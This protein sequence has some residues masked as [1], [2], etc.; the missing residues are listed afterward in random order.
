MI[1]A[2]LFKSIFILFVTL[3]CVT[4]GVHAQLGDPV[5]QYPVSAS[6]FV[7]DTQRN[8]IIVSLTN[9]NAVAIIDNNSQTAMSVIPTG[10]LAPIGVA[11]SADNNELYV[12]SSITPMIEV[13]DINTMMPVRS[14]S[15]PY[16]VY[17][18]AV[19]KNNVLFATPNSV[20]N[21]GIM[22]IDTVNGFVFNQFDDNGN[23]LVYQG[24]LLAVSPDK[25]ILYFGNRGLSPA[26]LASFDISQPMSIPQLIFKNPHGSLG[27]NGQDIALTRDGQFISFAVGGGNNTIGYDIN[28]LTT[29][30]FNTVGMFT[31][32]A[33]PEEIV[34]NDDGSLAFTVHTSG[35]IDVFDANT[36][37]QVSTIVT[38]AK[39]AELFIDNSGLKLYAAFDGVLEVYSAVNFVMPISN[40]YFSDPA[41]KACFD[42]Q[43][44][45]HGWQFME[46]ITELACPG[47][48]IVDINGI[49]MLPRLKK[50]D[51]SDNAIGFIDSLRQISSLR[52]LRINKNVIMDVNPLQDLAG[53]E[54]LHIG[55]NPFDVYMLAPAINNMRGLK[56]LGLAGMAIQDINMLP[57]FDPDLGQP[58]DIQELDL[59]RTGYQFTTALTQFQ[60]LHILNLADN[61]QLDLQPLTMMTSLQQF[62]VANNVDIDMFMLQQVIANNH[63]LTHLNLNNIFIADVGN[64]PLFNP[65]LGQPYDIQ[66]LHLA[67]TGL[68][69]IQLYDFPNLHVL[70]VSKN[71][72]EMLWPPTTLTSLR[73][74]D[75]SGNAGLQLPQVRSV[76]E[77]NPQ[78]QELGL[79]DIRIEKI[80]NLPLFNPANGTPL[81]IRAL[82]LRN[83]GLRSLWGIEML[84]NL[85]ALDVSDNNVADILLLQML[86]QLRELDLSGNIAITEIDLF[87]VLGNKPKL[88]KLGLAGI[89]LPDLNSL[90]LFDNLSGRPY[91]LKSLNL[92]N[93]G[94]TDIYRLQEFATL[95]ELDL[96]Q[97]YIVDL[98]PLQILNKLRKLDLSGNL[99]LSV[100]SLY[101]ALDMKPRLT[102]LGLADI[103]IVDLYILPLFDYYQNRPYPLEEIN[104]RNTGIQS[105][106]RLVEFANLRKIDVSHNRIADIYPLGMMSRITDLDLGYNKLFDVWPLLSAGLFKLNALDLSGNTQLVMG[107]VMQ[108]IQ[109]NAHLTR[110][111]VAGFPLQ[112]LGYL[113]I[114]N[115]ASGGPY[116]LEYLNVEN[117]GLAEIY[118]LSQFKTLREVNISNNQLSDLAPLSAL[119]RL[120]AVT[121]RSVNAMNLNGME[122]YTGLRVLDVSGNN[123]LDP[124]Q[125]SFIVGNNRLLCELGVN[126]VQFADLGMLN[127]FDQEYQRPYALSRLDIK[128]TGLSQINI[129]EQFVT[130]QSLNIASNALYDLFPLRQLTRMK[131]L[132]ISYNPS[133]PNL[134]GTEQ[135]NNLESLNVSGLVSPGVYADLG[136]LLNTSMHL[137]NYTAADLG[138][139]S[140]YEIPMPPQ[141]TY[142]TGLRVL[143]VSHNPLMDLQ[144]LNEYPNLQMVVLQ[145]IATEDLNQLSTLTQLWQIDLTNNDQFFC[146]DLNNLQNALPQ[147]EILRPLS[148]RLN[149]IP[150]LTLLSPQE[151][152]V[153]E[154]NTG[155][156]MSA[157][158]MDSEDGDLSA[159]IRWTSSLDGYLG[160]ASGFIPFLSAGDH[161]ITASVTDSKG[162]TSSKSVNIKVN[163]IVLTYCSSKGNS[164]YYE[165][166]NSINLVNQT[167]TTGNNSGY[168]DRTDV[169]FNMTRGGSYPLSMNP[170]FRYGSYNE[171]WVAWIDFNQDGTFGAGEQVYSGASRTSIV[172]NITIPVAAKAGKT[173][174]RIAMR[175][176]S[177]PTACGSYTWGETEDYTVDLQ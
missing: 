78:L 77:V 67:N 71:N 95:E 24:G 50:L 106:D 36:Y 115:G 3:A 30:M 176:G 34:Y 33:Y 130:L 172:A 97:N 6:K 168:V 138:A 109:Q 149:A 155:V 132:D 102:S 129:L 142:Q 167:I 46:E 9:D 120:S 7:E 8:Q 117:T 61:P 123:Q 147:T 25:N 68:T 63:G 73:S 119:P 69:Q 60:N 157:T 133:L 57:L 107:D 18:L 39:A 116:A 48:G 23:V 100:S 59:Q 20:P 56:S 112:N 161:V 111:G 85:E 35:Q 121:M 108:L 86:P 143:D 76:I 134:I 136:N 104:L 118:S 103:P 80:E 164:T 28:K 4:G 47:R 154:A 96:S 139:A 5:T 175:Y 151:G 125:I 14:I 124:A 43:V 84:A 16:P 170:G 38:P 159:Q 94:I 52:E 174:M 90:P 99:G 58:Y 42:E 135:L 126:N 11:I 32:G 74:L 166:V 127:L 41:L 148:C 177:Y 26:T 54:S 158:A 19:G 144:R 49:D 45:V 79:A 2:R 98:Y 122:N 53:L 10:A 44:Q 15:L 31:T 37:Q 87:Q 105:V 141:F 21:N 83:T 150:T 81:D 128:G 163:P 55:D 17:D 70:D 88:Q 101:P 146:I 137:K 65:E 152:S 1:S 12:G 13:F 114:F 156:P 92:S 160:M 173:R 113:P 62:N 29:P 140:L 82:N 66:E 91:A 22:Q 153:Y 64:L 131:H 27:S 145:D 40:A 110:L 89:R 93:T 51:L 162:A 75:L 169:V 171:F 72:I 165:W